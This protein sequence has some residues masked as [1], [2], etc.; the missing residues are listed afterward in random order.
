MRRRRH[1]CVWALLELAHRAQDGALLGPDRQLG[2]C[3]RRSRRSRETTRK[4]LWPDD[5]G[6]VFLF[7]ALYALRVARAAAQLPA[8]RVSH[9]ERGRARLPLVSQGQV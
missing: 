2:F 5:D 3:S 6:V 8:A 9:V 7:A 1:V 4:N